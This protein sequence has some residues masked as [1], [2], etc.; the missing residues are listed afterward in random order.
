[1][2]KNTVMK[3]VNNGIDAMTKK[4][5][6]NYFERRKFKKSCK[7]FG[8]DVGVSVASTVITDGIYAVGHGVG[9]GACMVVHGTKVVVGKAATAVKNK[10]GKNDSDDQIIAVEVVE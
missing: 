6:M 1:M 3:K 9:Y 7:K 8:Y 2:S 10:F 5:G 4:A